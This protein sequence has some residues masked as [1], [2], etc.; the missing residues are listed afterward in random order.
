ME[1]LSCNFVLEGRRKSRK[2][3]GKNYPQE[4]NSAQEKV[5]Y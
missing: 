5:K 2:I 3:Q 4:K 1:K